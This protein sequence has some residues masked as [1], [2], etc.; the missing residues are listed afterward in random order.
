MRVKVNIEI[1]MFKGDLAPKA[2]DDWL[3]K[4]ESYFIVDQF[5]SQEKVAFA[6][7]NFSPNALSWWEYFIQ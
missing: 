4:I 1:D 3:Q 2:L 5:S 7:L 6:T